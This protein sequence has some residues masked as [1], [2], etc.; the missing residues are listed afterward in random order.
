MR[1]LSALRERSTGRAMQD[2][3]VWQAA[4]LLLAYPDDGFAERLDAVDEILGHISGPAAAL[5]E[6]TA[7]ALR[8]R[9]P[10]A[11]AMDYVATFDLR[12]RATM[13]LTYWTAGDT[14][15]RGRE[16]LAFATAYREAG[17]QPPSGEAPDHLTVALEFA[18]TVDP[19]AGRRLLVQ[20]RVPID[21]LRGALADANSPYEPVV[22][23]ICETLPAATDQEV[24]RAERL[25]QAGPP[26]EAVGLQP[27][28]LTVPPRKGTPGV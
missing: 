4:S 16:M 23:A 13:Y 7:A 19:E 5:L 15:N 25:A 10:M 22:A 17:A 18:A 20:H 1:L 3:L 11:A 2:R 12:R 24:R 9:E 21:V 8:A 27:F 14:R 26:A 6:Q 28:T